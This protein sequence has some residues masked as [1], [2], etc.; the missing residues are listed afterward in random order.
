MHMLGGSTIPA[1]AAD[2]SRSFALSTATQ[3]LSTRSDSRKRDNEEG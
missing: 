1:C 3:A 2:I